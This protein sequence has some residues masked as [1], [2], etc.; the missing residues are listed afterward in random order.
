[1][2]H[3]PHI[4]RPYREGV[5]MMVLNS[6]NQVLVGRRIDNDVEAWQMPQGGIDNG[7][8]PQQAA[9][10]ELR[11]EIG[12]DAVEILAETS[13]WLYYDLPDALANKLWHGRYA[14]Q[15]QKWFLMRFVGNESDININ[16]AIP[17]FAEWDWK[18]VHTLPELIVDFKRNLY[19][20][21]IAE[22]SS[23]FAK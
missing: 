5:G 15:M 17:E 14:G 20:R 10:R 19:H 1:M 8:N 3:N 12:T 13:D 11:E 9:L 22:F 16:T 2:S 6:H 23:H 21:V 4:Q 7:E 18:E